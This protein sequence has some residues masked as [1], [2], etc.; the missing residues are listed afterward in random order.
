[1]RVPRHLGKLGKSKSG[2]YVLSCQDGKS[3]NVH[4]IVAFI[5]EHADGTK[6]ID[7]IS[8]QLIKA[9]EIN[10][11]HMEEEHENVVLALRSLEK[12][13]LIEYVQTR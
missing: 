9:L 2:N 1:M 10:E 6:T 5:W 4:K 13:K 8:E 11:E 12:K 3:Y 7:D